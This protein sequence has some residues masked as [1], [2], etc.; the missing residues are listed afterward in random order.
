MPI[1]VEKFKENQGNVKG[2]VKIG[3][4]GKAWK[5]K[6]WNEPIWK[7]PCLCASVAFTFIQH[8]SFKIYH[9]KSPLFLVRYF[10]MGMWEFEN[11]KMSQFEKSP[12]LCA[13]LAF[14]SSFSIYQFKIYHS[15]PLVPLLILFKMWDVR[16]WK[17]DLMIWK[18]K[19]W[20]WG[21]GLFELVHGYN[22]LFDVRYLVGWWY[23]NMWILPVI[24]KSAVVVSIQRDKFCC[25]FKRPRPVFSTFSCILFL[26]WLNVVTFLIFFSVTFSFPGFL[27]RNNFINPITSII[28][29]YQLLHPFLILLL[30]LITFLILFGR[31]ETRLRR[32]PPCVRHATGVGRNHCINYKLNHQPVSTI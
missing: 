9:S 24:C 17:C 30:F 21:E 6:I 5:K 1:S 32:N 31:S 28:N 19:I 8:L 15:N 10:E 27:W 11:L 12:C 4:G 20:K 29:L 7:S 3:E 2:N 22:S 25:S 23:G 16:I 13:S 14:T 26:S 18:W